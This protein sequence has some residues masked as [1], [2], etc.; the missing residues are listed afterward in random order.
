M[1]IPKKCYPK[2]TSVLRELLKRFWKISFLLR[3]FFQLGHFSCVSTDV[4]VDWPGAPKVSGEWINGG[5]RLV[6]EGHGRKRGDH[7][8]PRYQPRLD[9]NFP[10][11]FDRKIEIYTQRPTN[12]TALPEN[13]TF[14]QLSLI[15]AK[16][17]A[18]GY[19]C[20][21]KKIIKIVQNMGY[22][23]L[24]PKLVQ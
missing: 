16:I 21:F 24:T 9:L 18:V 7:C 23:M 5:V 15:F 22:W 13:S 11:R 4:F 10:N 6:G 1:G 17:D 2:A 14:G 19:F 8:L 12:S 3:H 20:N